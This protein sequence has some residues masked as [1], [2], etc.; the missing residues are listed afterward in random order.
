MKESRG[1]DKIDAV[2]ELNHHV[3]LQH[4][5]KVSVAKRESKAQMDR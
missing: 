2:M 1:N 3:V 4:Q 5:Q